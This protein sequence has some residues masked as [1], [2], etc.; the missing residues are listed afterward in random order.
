[1]SYE[2]WGPLSDFE[3]S[4][5]LCGIWNAKPMDVPPPVKT[6][7]AFTKS[8]SCPNICMEKDELGSGDLEKSDVVFDRAV[9]RPAS[10]PKPVVSEELDFYLH[11]DFFGAWAW[12]YTDDHFINLCLWASARQANPEVL[13]FII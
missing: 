4:L 11:P 3:K 7:L 9:Q 1:M 13:D 6:T 12:S 10:A 8:V 2:L 5:S